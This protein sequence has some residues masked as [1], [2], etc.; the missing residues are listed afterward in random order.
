MNGGGETAAHEGPPQGRRLRTLEG[1]AYFIGLLI[2]ATIGMLVLARENYV[3]LF[4]LVGALGGLAVAFFGGTRLC[5]PLYF[6]STFGTILTFPFLPISVNRLLALLLFAA[7]CFEI[8]R[9]RQVPHFSIPFAIFLVFQV[10]YLVAAAFLIPDHPDAGYPFESFYYIFLTF[11]VCLG[12]TSKAW[13]RALLA[14]IVLV[15][16]LITVIPGLIELATGRDLTLR[17]FRGPLRRLDGLSM[18]AIVYAFNAI[19]AIPLAFTLFISSRSTPT[20]TFY[21][22]ASLA[23]LMMSLATLNR[24]TPITLV[25]IALVYIPLV[26]WKHKRWLVTPMIVGALLVAPFVAG[27]LV[28]RLATATDVMQDPSL[29]VRRDKAVIAWDMIRESPFVGVGHGYYQYIWR[30][31]LVRGDMVILQYLWEQRQYIDLGYLQILTEYGFIGLGLF[32]PLVL[33]TIVLLI[34][35]YRVSL[36]LSD[37]WWSNLIATLAALYSQFLVSM[38]IMDSFVTPR[39]YILYGLIFA[40]CTAIRREYH[41]EH[42]SV[43]NHTSDRSERT[44]N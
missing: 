38:L 42:S 29:A 20:R 24:Q 6:L 15:T 28:G 18:N 37:P 23:L 14:G 36:R 13:Q 8:L 34:K 7:W 21:I 12:Y 11:L 27:Q 16:F 33:S 44:E 5:F 26:R 10:Y 2:A 1:Y 9:H 41:R 39:T 17:G 30:D 43:T 25:A 3:Y 4:P 35:F 32:V 22:V 31:Y 40:A 19:Y